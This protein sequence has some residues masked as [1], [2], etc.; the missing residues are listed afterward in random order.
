MARGFR[1][2]RGLDQ[3][4][5]RRL[6][7]DE[8]RAVKIELNR[9]LRRRHSMCSCGALFGGDGV[10]C[11]P[12]TGCAHAPAKAKGDYTRRWTEEEIVAAVTP[13]YLKHRSAR[14]FGARKYAQT[15]DPSVHPAPHTIRRRF[16]TFMN[17]V[18]RMEATCTQR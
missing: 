16:G 9:E 2:L 14:G 4:R 18:A 1:D 5:T 3:A 13:L 17:L 10:L 7:Y 11:R 8:R 6:S 15:R 12:Q